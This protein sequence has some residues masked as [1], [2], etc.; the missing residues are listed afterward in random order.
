MK[1]NTQKPAVPAAFA[2]RIGRTL[3]RTW[4]GVLRLERNACAW[5]MAQGLP[6]GIAKALPL[7]FRLAVLGVVLYAAFWLAVL[8]LS[9]AVAVWNARNGNCNWMREP[10]WMNGPAGFGYYTY[11]GYRIDPHVFD[12]D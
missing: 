12:D 7:I 5:L 10:E 9:I 6:A 8:A 11:D 3:G 2:E 1:L 4:R